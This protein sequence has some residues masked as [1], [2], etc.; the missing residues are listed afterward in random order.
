MLLK[1]KFIY[2]INKSK[3]S[4][5]WFFSPGL[6]KTKERQNH[7]HQSF[8]LLFYYRVFLAN[9]RKMG[10]EVKRERKKEFFFK[11]FII[12][13]GKKKG[14]LSNGDDGRS[15]TGTQ[16]AVQPKKEKRKKSLAHPFHLDWLSCSCVGTGTAGQDTPI[17][18]LI[19][20]IL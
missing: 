4:L 6:E 1:R 5:P 20:T 2:F 3:W 9:S 8:R 16:G 10:R 7:I 14:T 13:K 11:M 18:P 15:W 17:H 12:F 19:Y